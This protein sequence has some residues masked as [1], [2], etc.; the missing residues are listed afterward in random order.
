MAAA[1]FAT[2]SSSWI[3]TLQELDP[4]VRMPHVLLAKFDL[5]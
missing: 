2:D 4:K 3:D 5:K 1:D